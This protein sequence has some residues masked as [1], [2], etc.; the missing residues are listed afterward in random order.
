M[1]NIQQ[2]LLNTFV[3]AREFARSSPATV[4]VLTT[5]L[6]T[7]S[8][9][10]CCCSPT[11]HRLAGPDPACTQQCSKGPSH[12]EQHLSEAALRAVAALA[13]R[14]AVYAGGR[15]GLLAVLHHNLP[16][17]SRAQHC[18][19]VEDLV[20]SVRPPLEDQLLLGLAHAVQLLYGLH[21]LG[22]EGLGQAVS[23]LLNRVG[24]QHSMAH[25][26]APA[27]CRAPA[28]SPAPAGTQSCAAA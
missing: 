5:S 26:T 3:C 11:D 27:S 25:W 9:C 23:H 7:W 17:L 22:V 21:Y 10:C 19:S 28:G 2:I 20:Y 8:R 16:Q 13:P 1:L 24:G 12:N 4:L 14:R 15:A 6:A 18:S